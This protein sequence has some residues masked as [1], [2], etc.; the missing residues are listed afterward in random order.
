MSVR[1]VV[2][3]IGG[4]LEYTPD[5]RI[6]E[7][8]EARLGLA[9]G[10]IGRRLASVFTDGSYGRISEAQVLTSIMEL[11]DLSR[12]VADEFMADLWVEYL[13]TPNHELIT[14]FRRL[15]DRCPTA[16]LSNSFVGARPR[17][18]AH[19]G[20]DGLCDTVV[21]SHEV[22]F[23]KPEPEIYLLTSERLGLPPRATPLSGR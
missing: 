5:L 19:L 7:G 10:E 20:L 2:F 9:P 1:G 17:E 16:I 14:Y 6:Q 3:D 21:Y 23:Y 13:G 4:V 11:L 22:G 15:R 8:W 18:E 12:P